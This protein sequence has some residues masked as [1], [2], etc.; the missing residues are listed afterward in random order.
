MISD[1]LNS[2]IV[3]LQIIVVSH[4]Y[5]CFFAL[6]LA[7]TNK[8]IKGLVLLDLPIPDENYK[9]YL[10]E[11]K[12]DNKLKH[13]VLLP[14]IQQNTKLIS[15]VHLIISLHLLKKSEYFTKLCNQ[16]IHSSIEVHGTSHMIHIDHTQTIIDRILN[17]LKLVYT[18]GM[19]NNKFIETCAW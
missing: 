2:K 3:L 5:G 7:N 13:F 4:S 9:K 6:E 10:E 8:R 18:T 19:S 16:N 15:Q 11:S 17:L 14:K 12:Q 1:E